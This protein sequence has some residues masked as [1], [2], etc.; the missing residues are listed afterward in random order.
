MLR[1]LTK[2]AVNLF[3]QSWRPA[4]RTEVFQKLSNKEM[5]TPE[6]VK[7]LI[8]API[9]FHSRASQVSLYHKKRVRHAVTSSFS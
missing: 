1:Q 5:A 2:Q 3:S 6:L 4:T 7:A 8:K 9:P